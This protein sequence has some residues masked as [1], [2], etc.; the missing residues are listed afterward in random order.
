MATPKLVSAKELQ[1]YTLGQA[2]AFKAQKEPKLQSEITSVVGKLSGFQ[3]EDT[4]ILDIKLKDLDD[5]K[6]ITAWNMSS[7][8]SLSALADAKQKGEVSPQSGVLQVNNRINTLFTDAGLNEKAGPQASVQNRLSSLMSKDEWDT[9]TGYKYYRGRTKKKFEGNLHAGTKAVLTRLNQ[10]GKKTERDF[11]GFKYFSGLR[12]SDMADIEVSGYDP[13]MGTL[14]FIEGKSANKPK[15]EKTVILRPMARVFLEQAIGERKQGKIFV[16]DKKLTASVNKELKVDMPEVERKSPAG[17]VVKGGFTLS[18]YRNA[19]EAIL[20]ESGLEKDE[21]LFAAGRMGTD[22]ASK[23]IDDETYNEVIEPKLL[24]TDAKIV[25]YSETSNVP[26]YLSDIGIDPATVPEELRSVVIARDLVTSTRLKKVLNPEFLKSLPVQGGGMTATTEEG[27]YLFQA[28]PELSEAYRAYAIED[29]SVKTTESRVAQMEGEMKLA[30]IMNSPEYR[31]A[32]ETLQQA[33]PTAKEPQVTVVDKNQPIDYSDL[34][35][36]VM[37]ALNT[38]G[39]LTKRTRQAGQ[40]IEEQSPTQTPSIGQAADIFGTA[41]DVI[42]EGKASGMPGTEPETAPSFKNFARK[43]GRIYKAG[44]TIY[45]AYMLKKAAQ[46]QLQP[47]QPGEPYTMYDIGSDLVGGIQKALKSA[48][49]V[50]T[51]TQPSISPE[52]DEF[53]DIQRDLSKSKY[54]GDK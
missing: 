49:S 9:Y 14:T 50:S 43:A 38:V 15:G 25:A 33:A 4:P 28:D 6:A 22:E 26:Q 44:R 53:S 23:Y 41:L 20:L 2:L 5:G 48:P 52:Y 13:V 34:P 42:A 31:A 8:Y 18:D 46:E 3:Y 7:P 35:Q 12:L 17:N 37:D 24:K 16:D 40:P 19:E 29:Y 32:Q 54:N 51:P 47:S 10:E 21:R 39:Q 30:E 1:E 11:L 27:T 36:N 45:G